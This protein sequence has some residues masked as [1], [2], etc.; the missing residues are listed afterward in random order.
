MKM[1][2]GGT[3]RHPDGPDRLPLPDGVAQLHVDPRKVKE[4]A[5]EPHAMI[6]HQKIAFKREGAGGGENDD[7]VGRGKDRGAETPGKIDACMGC[8]RLSG[9]DALGAEMPGDAPRDR[10][11]EVLPPAFGPA[12]DV[13][14]GGDLFELGRAV[15]LEFGVRLG[16]MRQAG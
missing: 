3:S 12:Q 15:R 2:A 11:D 4:G 7:A 10:P 16:V 5:V 13:S 6:E 1:R 14:R 9:I 8:T